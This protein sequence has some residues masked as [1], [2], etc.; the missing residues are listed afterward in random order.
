[1]PQSYSDSGW[2]SLTDFS[3]VGRAASG[4]GHPTHN[5][6][7]ISQS[8]SLRGKIWEEKQKTRGLLMDTKVM[9]RANA[10]FRGPHPGP[11]G[12]LSKSRDTFLLHPERLLA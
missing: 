1:M 12:P 9:R 7:F 3:G 5:I 2:F 6:F 4:P 11:L 10:Y 8:A